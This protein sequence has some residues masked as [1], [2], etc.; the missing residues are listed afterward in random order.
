[1]NY[2]TAVQGITGHEGTSGDISRLVS[3]T[4]AV[5][6]LHVFASDCC[7]P[8][9]ACNWHGFTV[10]LYCE[11]TQPFNGSAGKQRARL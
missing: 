9:H 10:V 1:M 4:C 11:S 6:L 8:A 7:I 5:A 2:G 3:A